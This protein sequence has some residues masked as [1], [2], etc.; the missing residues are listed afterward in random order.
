[1]AG[2][3]SL[4]VQFIRELTSRESLER[5]PEPDLVMS[6]PDNVEEYR[7]AG[8]IDGN[9]ASLYLFSALQLCQ[10]I[11]PGDR[12]L[13]LACGP[14][15]LLL[16][17]AELN[18]EAEFIGIDL[19]PEMLACAEDLRQS[20]GARNVRFERGDI[21]QLNAHPDASVDVVMS[22]LSLHHLP[23]LDL[24]QRCIAEIA[25]VARSDAGLFLLDFSRLKRRKTIEYFSYQ[26]TEGLSRFLAED[27]YNSMAAAFHLSDYRALLPQ[28]AGIPGVQL[29]TTFGVPFLM[30][31]RS[32]LRS[33]IGVSARAWLHGYWKGLTPELR[34]DFDAMRLFFRLGGLSVPD[35]GRWQVPSTR[36]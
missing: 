12:V 11:R 5:H 21:T 31:L 25:R 23:T 10:L 3:L 13:D 17:V 26:R 36:A 28:L 35:P 2:D 19:S 29:S 32:K 20:S 6:N 22:T 8:L 1:M 14:A 33:E 24:L 34:K 27:Y 16:M 4:A 18:P 9:G 15:N 7:R 30:Q